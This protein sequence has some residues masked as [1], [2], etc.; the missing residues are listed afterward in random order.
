MIS[1]EGLDMNCYGEVLTV[2]YRKDSPL[3]LYNSMQLKQHIE[4]SFKDKDDAKDSTQLYCCKFSNDFGKFI[5]A[6]GSQV[7]AVK[8][9]DWSGKGMAA[10]DQLSHAPVALD[11][12]NDVS[13]P[14]QLLAIGGGEGAIRVF[15][16]SYMQQS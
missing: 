5:F 11:S 3:Q 14:E 1:G 13:K 10:I 16:F 4:W 2:S 12:S 6:G 8:V 9:F 7:N 15:K